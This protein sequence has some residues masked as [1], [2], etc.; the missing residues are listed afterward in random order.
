M[1]DIAQAR[2][3]ILIVHEDLIDLRIIRYHGYLGSWSSKMLYRYKAL[4]TTVDVNP[5]VL[6]MQ[7][8]TFSECMSCFAADAR[9]L[10]IVRAIKVHVVFGNIAGAFVEFIGWPSMVKIATGAVPDC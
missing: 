1:L 9:L 8:Y 5:A 4:P 7:P 6:S 3:Q 2:Y 10:P